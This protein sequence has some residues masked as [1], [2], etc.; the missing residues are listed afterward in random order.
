MKWEKSEA[1]GKGWETGPGWAPE[2]S[3]AGQGEDAIKRGHKKG[4]AWQEW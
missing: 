4:V 1:A 2:V 3:C